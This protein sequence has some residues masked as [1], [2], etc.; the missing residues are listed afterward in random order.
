MI[1]GVQMRANK[2]EWFSLTWDIT[3]FYNP[4]S[5]EQFSEA[6]RF[7]FAE[8]DSNQIEGLVI[9][10][11]DRIRLTSIALTTV[12]IVREDGVRLPTHYRKVSF[13]LVISRIMILGYLNTTVL[14]IP[15]LKR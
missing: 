15:L 5:F 10:Q 2:G 1:K 11:F 7:I 13:C 14:C 6:P 4:L 12:F 3:D 8:E 9:N